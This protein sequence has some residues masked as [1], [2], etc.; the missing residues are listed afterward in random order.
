MWFFFLT[1][2]NT[3]CYSGVFFCFFLNY[4]HTS[5]YKVVSHF[6]FNFIHLLLTFFTFFFPTTSQFSIPYRNLTL[7]PSYQIC[8]IFSY[9]PFYLSNVGAMYF[10]FFILVIWVF[11]LF[12]LPVY[13]KICQFCGSFQGGN[14]RFSLLFFY[15]PG[16]WSLL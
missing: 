9:N 12:S 13:L 10:Y 6:A 5:G 3:L 11:I 14:F 4:S 1:Y 8:W 2:Q 16:C 15:S 7:S